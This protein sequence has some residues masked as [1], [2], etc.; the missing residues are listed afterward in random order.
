MTSG[1][2]RTGANSPALSGSG[3]P[4]LNYDR[5]RRLLANPQTAEAEARRVLE[6]S[7]DD[8]D[9][10]LLLGAAL[11]RLGNAATARTILEEVVRSEPD[12]ALALFELG[13]CLARLELHEEAREALARAV[14]LAAT[15]PAAWLALGDELSLPRGEA[16]EAGNPAAGL[17]REAAEVLRRGGFSTAEPLLARALAHAPGFQE[18][19]FR[20]AVALLVQ[21]KGQAALPVIEELIRR[22]PANPF[23]RE[24]FASALY[25]IGEYDRAIAQYG[26]F[27]NENGERP[28]AWISYGRALRAIGKQEH[29]VAAFRRAVEVLPG[30]AE[31]YRT[32]ATVKTIRIEPAAIDTLRGLLARPQRLVSSR[33]QLHFALAKALEDAGAFPDAFEN[34][35]ASQQLQRVG[36]AY[37]PESFTNLM[38]RIKAL[39]TRAF[40]RAR[41]G[42]GCTASDAIFVVGMPRAGSTLIQEILAAH[43]DIERTGELRDMTRLLAELR[44]ELSGGPA[45][46]YP[47]LIAHVAPQQLRALGERYLARTRPRRKRGTARFVDKYLENF[48]YTGLIHL[49][50]PNAK[51]VD[52]RRHPLDCGF[53]CF[54]NYFPEGP[55]WS[56]RLEDIGRFYADYVELMA[57][58]DEVL[59]GRVHRLFYERLI[60]EPE[61]EVRRLLDYLDLPFEPECLRFH[62]KKQAIVTISI[63]QAR[64]PIYAEGVGNSRDFDPWLGPLKSALGA[65]LEAYPGVPRSYPRIQATMNLRLG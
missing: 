12:S 58:F 61:G 18:A 11:Q 56:H 15:S 38:Q 13:H 37:K 33:A 54:R 62:E 47:D 9:A 48:L 26:E 57:H 63:E 36:L 59:P 10:R 1:P 53:S 28:G 7:P 55:T 60:T 52:V 27:L 46:T 42:R 21:E 44:Q 8:V 34:Y 49:L 35:D 43:P 22:D 3:A 23:F 30:F 17:A 6:K 40:L 32:L 31:A 45:P 25:E 41:E 2:T 20:Y 64:Q 29:C 65:V 50:L 51:I 5:A 24:L 14:D 39:F 4:A 19:R 16:D